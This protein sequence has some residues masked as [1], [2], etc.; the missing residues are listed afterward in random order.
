VALC[1]LL[2]VV[3]G[4]TVTSHDAGLSVPGWSLSFG[5][6]M[7]EMNGGVFH[8]HGHRMVAT[9]VGMLVIGLVLWLWRAEPRRW[10]CW[11]GT[12][13]LGALIAQGLLGVLTVSFKLPK[14]VS[15]AHACLAQLVFSSTVAIA[16]FTSAAWRR[17]PQPVPDSGSPSVRSLAAALPV[18]LLTQLAL[19]A[20]YR[21][22]ALGI[23]PHMAGAMVVLVVVLGAAV[24]V[25][26]KYSNHA[27]LK[28]AAKSLMHITL[29]QV[30]L[31]T[32]AYI[33]RIMTPEAPHLMPFMVAF[34]VAHVAVG[35]LTMAASVIFAIQ[36][37]RNVEE[38]AT[39]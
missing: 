35:A 9:A 25:L 37:F 6:V 20:A 14:P 36:V 4:A 32:G 5:Q 16:V 1:T 18:L 17:G 30:V 26:Q 27:T 23:V 15:I 3:A 12:A 19:G 21:H 7:P 33:T 2:L 28:R 10:L 29:L 38:P 13:T 8:E 39:L 11:L 34:T 24:V 31:G 22:K